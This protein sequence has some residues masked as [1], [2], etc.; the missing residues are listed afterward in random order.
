MPGLE[1][2]KPVPVIVRVA[3]LAPNVVAD[4]LPTVGAVTPDASTTLATSTAVPLATLSVVTDALRTP[5]DGAWLVVPMVTVI[6]V[7]VAFTDAT[8]PVTVPVTPPWVKV[9]VLLPGVVSNPE[10]LIKSVVPLLLKLAVL[11]DTTGV[12]VATCTALPLF[13]PL[14]VTMAVRLP[15]V[16]GG[17]EK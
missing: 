12:T 5:V 13:T 8:V 14:V 3:A 7:P 2:S 6:C 17:V 15:A 4:V 11:A 10:P 9:T 1:V 16:I